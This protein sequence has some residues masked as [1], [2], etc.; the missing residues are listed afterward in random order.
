M[1]LA[2]DDGGGGTPVMLVHGLGTTR[3]VWAD[4]TEPIRAVGLRTVAVDQRGHGGSADRLPP[5]GIHDLA[6]DLRE[7]L[8]H[9]GIERAIVVGHS[10]GGRAMFDLALRHPDRVIAIVTVGAQSEAPVAPYRAVIEAVRAATVAEGVH[11]FRRAFEAAGEIPDRVDRDPSYRQEFETMFRANRAPMIIAAL[12]A[13]LAMETLTSR[14][15]EIR[16]PMLSVVGGEDTHFLAISDRY[17][18]LVRGCRTVIVP[19]C[20]H[21]PMVDRPRWFVRALVPFLRQAGD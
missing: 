15:P 16:C 7:T 21:Y 20:S 18:E 19:R 8:D 2:F 17:A 1:I 11:G 14:L 10:M 13:I 9:L 12:D 5:W 4:V 6:E 3:R